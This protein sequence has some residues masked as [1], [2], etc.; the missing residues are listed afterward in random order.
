MRR[1]GGYLK[2]WAAARY[3][4]IP[5][6]EVQ[7]MLESGELPGVRI[8]GQWR[9]PLERLEE[10]LDEEVS[11]EELKKLAEHVK[12]DPKKIES[13]FEETSRGEGEPEAGS[14]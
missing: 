2:P 8:E 10:W 1:L 4:G 11:Q 5:V 9:I 13:F 6:E 3:L 14:G 12:V 7:K